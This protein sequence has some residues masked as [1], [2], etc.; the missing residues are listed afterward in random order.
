MKFRFRSQGSAVSAIVL[1]LGILAAAMPAIGI[2]LQ[3]RLV[4][5][6]NRSKDADPREAVISF[7]PAG[8]GRTA[9]AAT[10]EAGGEHTLTTVRKD[11]S[12]RVLAVPLGAT[13]RFPNEDP[14][15]H[16][17]FSVSGRNRFDL[18]L[19][20]RGEAGEKTFEHAGVVRV[21][22]NVHPDMAASVL[23]LDTPYVARPAADGRFTISG[24]ASG[25]G[26]LTVWHERAESLVRTIHLPL[27]GALTLELEL[28]RPR[29]PSHLNKFGKPYDKRRGRRY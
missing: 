18:G 10:P 11:F 15:L 22:C 21:Y 5:D 28:S 17:V 3:G 25:E 2:E 29:V 27:D 9:G 23:V 13:V 26:T 4:I 12:P 14:I 6:D 8:G 7:V 1:L 24:L 19:F 16:N 20:G